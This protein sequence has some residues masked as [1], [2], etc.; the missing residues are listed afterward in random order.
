MAVTHEHVKAH[1]VL[2]KGLALLTQQLLLMSGHMPRA[3]SSAGAEAV[4]APSNDFTNRQ[5]PTCACALEKLPQ[6]SHLNLAMPG[7][8][9]DPSGCT[10]A[11]PQVQHRAPARHTSPH[12]RDLLSL[13]YR[14]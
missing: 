9:V 13:Q 4:T 14:Y 11:V 2:R 5:Q 6:L 12:E 7:A 1:P 10:L 8:R 3:A